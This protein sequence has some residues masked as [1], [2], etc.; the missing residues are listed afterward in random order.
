MTASTRLVT[1]LSVFTI[2]PWPA[3]PRALSRIQFMPFS[4][5]SIRYSRRSSFSV[6]ENPPTSPIPSVQSATVSGWLLTSHWAPYTPPASSSAVKTSRTGRRGFTPAR[7]R[8]RT[9]DSTIA[10]K[11]FMSTAP[12][13]QTHPSKISPANGSTFQSFGSAGTTSRWPCTSSGSADWSSP[14]Q[15]ATSVARP[16]SDS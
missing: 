8:A 1:A 10:S 11:S 12:R 4:A 7:C 16:G 14:S 9:T 6:I 13:P 15:C 5:V 3:V 2:D